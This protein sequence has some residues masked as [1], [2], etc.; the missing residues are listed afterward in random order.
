MNI[1][2]EDI[3]DFDRELK[4]TKAAIERLKA[5]LDALRANYKEAQKNTI[6]LLDK[7]SP[8]YTAI[9]IGK[10]HNEVPNSVGFVFG[11]EGNIFGY[12]E[13]DKKA[14]INDRPAIWSIAEDMGISAGCGNSHQHQVRTSRLVDGVYKVQDGKWKRIDNDPSVTDAESER[15]V[16]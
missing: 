5:E 7:C 2:K 8:Y 9:S 4:Y 3:M 14:R 16:T 13:D 10:S 15:I 12:N 1:N 11:A 6:L